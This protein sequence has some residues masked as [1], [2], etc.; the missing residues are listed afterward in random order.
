[1]KKLVFAFAMIAV[2]AAFSATSFSYQGAL[3]DAAGNRLPT[4]DRNKT[5]EFR[6]YESVNAVEAV[7]G[8]EFNVTLDEDGMFNVELSDVGSPLS[9]NPDSPEN[10]ALEDVITAYAGKDLFIGLTVDGSV[11]EI[12]PRQKVLSVPVAA[13]AR[14]VGEAK[15]SFSVRGEA[16]IYGSAVVHS[17]LTVKGTSELSGPV[18]LGSTQRPD[19]VVT[20]NGKAVAANGL[21]VTTGGLTVQSGGISLG[22][23]QLTVG[24]VDVSLPIGVIVMWSGA[25]DK[26]PAGWKL[27]DGKNNTPDLRG[28]FIVG[29][30]DAN[31][32]AA[33]GMGYKS[34]A[35]GGANT[36][37]LDVN[38][39][40]SHSHG[41]SP[42]KHRAD[43]DDN[44][45]PHDYIMSLDGETVTYRTSSVGGGEAHENRPPFYALCFIMRVGDAK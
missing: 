5:I 26:I 36:V 35:T 19:Q 14:N 12:S 9:T 11:G 38:Q 45:D 30:Q 39:I 17:N 24:G 6:L 31:D 33:S 37:K 1:M 2:S 41:L 15:G 4:Q 42:K 40:P 18:K 23:G 10:S 22:S 28:R 29:A 34:G 16:T 13:Y 3:L 44:D 32:P 43:N 21:T 8:R 7:W 25:V 27:C 20:F